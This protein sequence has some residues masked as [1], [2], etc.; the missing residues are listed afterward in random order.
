MNNDEKLKLHSKLGAA[1][2]PIVEAETTVDAANVLNC[3][4]SLL[5][6]VVEMLGIN[7]ALTNDEV[8]GCFKLL[9]ENADIYIVEV[10]K[11]REGKISSEIE[12]PGNE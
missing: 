1:I 7:F 3:V 4:N 11:A 9:K 12:L 6:H 2:G 10:K 8:T 5:V